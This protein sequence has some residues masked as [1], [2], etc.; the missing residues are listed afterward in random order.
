[1]SE[2]KG[3]MNEQPCMEDSTPPLKRQRLD[4]DRYFEPEH[5]SI[6]AMLS[7]PLELIFRQLH[8]KPL[9]TRAE[10]QCFIKINLLVQEM[11]GLVQVAEKMLRQRTRYKGFQTALEECKSPL[12]RPVPILVRIFE[13]Q[14]TTALQGVQGSLAILMVELSS[15]SALLRQSAEQNW[16]VSESLLDAMGGQASQLLALEKRHLAELEEEISR[17]IDALMSMAMVDYQEEKKRHQESTEAIGARRNLFGKSSCD[18]MDSWKEP[19]ST[20]CASL[21][22]SLY[23]DKKVVGAARTMKAFT[24]PEHAYDHASHDADEGLEWKQRYQDVDESQNSFHK[25]S[26]AAEALANLALGGHVKE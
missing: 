26:T 25:K 4:T 16:S 1:M 5:L 3:M 9:L 20:I 22:N 17:R 14:T 21:F 18:T 11:D 6:T 19:L 24:Q 7:V 12:L 2:S 8:E 23:D 13:N 10:G 15:C